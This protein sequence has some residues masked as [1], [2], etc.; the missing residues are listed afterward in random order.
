VKIDVTSIIIAHWQTL[1]NAEKKRTSYFD[2]CAF[3]VTPVILAVI[4][5][6]S[7]VQFKPDHYN[8]SITFFGIFLALLLNIQ[9]AIFA[10]FQR[11]WEPRLDPRQASLQTQELADRRQLLAELNVNIS[12]L[13]VFSCGSIALILVFFISSIEIGPSVI[14]LLYVHFLLT[15]LMIVKRSHALFQKEY[16]D[17]PRAD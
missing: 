8:A 2:I 7:G 10:I 13:I 6:A 5:Y 4:T 16:R 9:V 3:Y 15:F 11:K 14:V 17:S 12:Y 1:Y